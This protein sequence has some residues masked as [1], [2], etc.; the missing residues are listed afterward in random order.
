MRRGRGVQWC[1]ELRT[2]A[3]LEEA[4]DLWRL[5]PRRR[6][7]GR[8]NGT[9]G[10]SSEAESEWRKLLSHQGSGGESALFKGTTTR[11][12]SSGN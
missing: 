8:G 4:L 12:S 2:R 6:L 9:R 3:H 5:D 11:L 7:R 1:V 10:A